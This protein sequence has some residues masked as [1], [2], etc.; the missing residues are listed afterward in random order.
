MALGS[1]RTNIKIDQSGATPLM[2]NNVFPHNSFLLEKGAI[3]VWVTHSSDPTM[4]KLL[5]RTVSGNTFKPRPTTEAGIVFQ[6]LNGPLSG[7]DLSQLP[8]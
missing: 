6:L 3:G 4:F 2:H 5:N 1:T 7:N 8:A